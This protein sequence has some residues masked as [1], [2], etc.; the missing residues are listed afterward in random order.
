MEYQPPYHEECDDKCA[1]DRTPGEQPHDVLERCEAL[2]EHPVVALA[3]EY[4]LSVKAG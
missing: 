3:V 4:E 1:H 2:H